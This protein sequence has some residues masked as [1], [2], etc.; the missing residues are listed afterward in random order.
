MNIIIVVIIIVENII[1]VNIIILDAIVAVIL[2]IIWFD[3]AFDITCSELV[4]R[5][6]EDKTEITAIRCES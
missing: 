4:L 5:E 1:I 2:I 3:N 6:V